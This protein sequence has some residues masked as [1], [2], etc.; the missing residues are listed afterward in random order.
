MEKTKKEIDILI[1]AYLSGISSDE[2]FIGLTEYLQEKPENI[3][4]FDQY[5]SNWI[6][7]SEESETSWLRLKSKIIRLK[8]LDNKLG[9][10]FHLPYSILRIASVLMVGLIIGAIISSGILLVKNHADNPIVFNAPKGEKSIIV[11]P[12]SS[13]VWLNGGTILRTNRNFG[14]TNRKVELSGEAYFEVTKN[15]RTPFVVVTGPMN[16][17]VLGT[18]FNV[19][20]YADQELIETTLK[21]GVIELSPTTKGVFRKF[22]MKKD[23]IAVFDRTTSKMLLGTTDVETKLAWKNNQL[24]I[25]NENYLRV[26]RKL[27]NWYGVKFT[28]ENA[29]KTEPNY[30]MTIKTESLREILELISIITPIKY[31]IK[32]ENV[33]IQFKQP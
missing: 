19:S 33:A 29:P 10:K 31:E 14:I 24:I 6:S 7:R 13:K 28:F 8:I 3:T 11:L 18:K 27:E 2:D 5:K 21:E 25:E 12:D 15:H 23:E 32:G 17:R 22:I 16:V 20:A 30:S 9:R 4:Y 26:F 1:E